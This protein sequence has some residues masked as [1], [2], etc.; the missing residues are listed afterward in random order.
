MAGIVVL[1]VAAVALIGYLVYFRYNVAYSGH[2]RFDFDTFVRAARRVEA[3][4][5]P[6]PR[7]RQYVYPPFVALL[8]A[9][10]AHAN[11]RHL[12]HVWIALV[13]VAPLVGVGAF[14]AS[15]ASRLSAWLCPLL[16]AFCA[17]SVLYTG[18]WP[19]SRELY[20]GQ[21]D[22]FVFS[23]LVLATLAA[24]RARELGRSA[25]IGVA[26]LIKVWP[27]AFGLSLLQRGVRRR[28][29]AIAL[30]VAAVVAMP[31]SALIAWGPSA[32]R[33]FLANVFDAHSQ[34]IVNDSV[35]GAPKLLFSRSGLARPM[36]VSE[37]LELLAWAIL[38]LWVVGLLVVALRT[39]GDPALCTWNV[40]FC[41]I[42]LLPVAHRQYAIL[43]LPLLWTWG[44][45]LLTEG[46]NLSDGLVIAVVVG[47]WLLQLKAWPYYGSSRA[48]SSVRY[49]VPFFADMIACTAS[50]IG[51]R[52]ATLRATR[53][54]GS[55]SAANVGEGAL[56]PR[57]RRL[58]CLWSHEV[59]RA[60]Q[61]DSGNRPD[62][63]DGT[64]DHEQV[65]HCAGE[66]R[67]DRGDDRRAKS[68]WD[69]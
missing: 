69:R 22:T 43:V 4:M 27:L 63:R 26:A 8:M 17:F 61:D 46:V 3:G 33:G 23:M 40:I 15:H 36:F 16:L 60:D 66:A 32:V 31:L 53:A 64:A 38:A 24:R 29:G 25:W 11:P 20:L 52:A 44:V 47:W 56:L 50:V 14:V 34:P 51:A 58:R 30:L 45:N 67:P 19:M 41:V 7:D 54:E 28:R 1:W 9:P 65:V 59:L 62:Q 12:W 55:T 42:L 2:G 13:I 39:A 21:I 5:S 10:F 37:P 35:W 49:C 18:Y 48:I 6:Y 68:R 57:A